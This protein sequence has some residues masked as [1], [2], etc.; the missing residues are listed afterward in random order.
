MP[1]FNKSNIINRFQFKVSKIGGREGTVFKAD[2]NT[3][4]LGL[5]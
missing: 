1:N 4:C 3:P 5:P 2:M